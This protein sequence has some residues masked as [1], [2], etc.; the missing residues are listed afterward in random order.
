MRTNLGDA[1]ALVEDD[2]LVGC[3]DC[4]E[5]VGDDDEG[6]VA[7]QGGHGVGDARFVFGVKGA[8]GLVEEDDGRGLQ[9]RAGDGNALAFSSGQRAP[10]LADGGVPAVRQA[11]DDL[12]DSAQ[13]SRFLDICAARVGVSD[14]HISFQGVVEEVDVLEDER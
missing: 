8:R 2:D 9:E 11:F 14:A 6:R 7:P 12:V 4:V 10:A 1:A 3:R 5:L 13:A